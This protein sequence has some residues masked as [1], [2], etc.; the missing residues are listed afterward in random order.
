MLAPVGYPV[1]HDSGGVATKLLI[2][3]FAVAV[4]GSIAIYVF[5]RNDQP[6][7]LSPEAAVDVNQTLREA[8]TPEDGTIPLVRGGEIY[9]ATFVRND[10]RFPVTLEGLGDLGEVDDVPY[11]PV[12]LRLGDGTEPDPSGTAVFAPQT[13]DPGEGVGVLVIY[14]PNPDLLCQLLT[15]EPTG[16]G[17]TIDGF[18]VTGSTY[19]VSFEQ[20]LTAAEPY[21]KVAPPSRADCE[22]AF[23]DAA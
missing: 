19:G 6:F 20:L 21:A 4:V 11:I 22:A 18:A 16:R 7:A 8:K 17:T 23:A 2:T 3:V 14:T 5:L 10:G 9:V 15:E 1:E 12:E 13:L